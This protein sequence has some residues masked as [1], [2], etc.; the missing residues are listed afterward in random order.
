MLG[1]SIF[2]MLES[3]EE[4]SDDVPKIISCMAKFLYFNSS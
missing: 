3:N 1:K 2:N 4:K